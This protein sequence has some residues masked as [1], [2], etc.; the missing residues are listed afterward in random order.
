[1]GTNYYLRHKPDCERCGRPFEPLHIGKSSA[2]WCFSLHVAPEDGINDLDDWRKLWR[3]PGALIRDE[4]GAS[5]S[6]EEMEVIITKRER[7]VEW[8]DDW[9]R[10][11]FGHYVSEADFHEQNHSERGPMG[12]LRS[13]LNDDCIKHGDGTWD[14][15]A[16][17]F[18]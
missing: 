10:S 1:M 14:C 9:W 6:I 16:S 5:L 7:K 15:I 17:S 11:L 2:G 3:Q 18:S 13:V 4:Y 8:D 12:L